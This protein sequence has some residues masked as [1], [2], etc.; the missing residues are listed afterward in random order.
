MQALTTLGIVRAS[1]SSR[2]PTYELTDHPIVAKIEE[3][4][5][6][7]G[8]LVTAGIGASERPVPVADRDAGDRPFGGV[9]RQAMASVVEEPCKG[10]PALQYIVDGPGGIVLRRELCLVGAQPGL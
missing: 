9:V 8:L 5:A 1:G 6:K 4:L 7:G 3:V 10:R 2:N